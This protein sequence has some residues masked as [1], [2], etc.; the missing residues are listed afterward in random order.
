MFKCEEKA[1]P[2]APMQ[3]PVF[4]LGC[5]YFLENFREVSL[6]E[7]QILD[8][9]KSRSVFEFLEATVTETLLGVTSK[10]I[11][12]GNRVMLA[13]LTMSL[14]KAPTKITAVYDILDVVKCRHKEGPGGWLEIIFNDG[15]KLRVIM[16]ARQTECVALITKHCGGGTI[17][18]QE[19]EVANTDAD[20]RNSAPL[21]EDDRDNV[22]DMGGGLVMRKESEDD[23]D[24]IDPPTQDDIKDLMKE[25]S[26]A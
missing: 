10:S 17:R 19:P 16:S 11:L 24:G 15:S 25:F 23:P 18:I 4:K 7:A 26:D 5:E 3:E 8:N 2:S 6:F 1:L 14:S 12:L 9:V 20:D 13:Q 22:G 21:L